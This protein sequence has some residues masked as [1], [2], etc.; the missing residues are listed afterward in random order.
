M[1]VCVCAVFLS[2]KNCKG[3]KSGTIQ[4]RGGGGGADIFQGPPLK[5]L[6]PGVC[7]CVCV[8]VCVIECARAILHI[9]DI[10][11]PLSQMIQW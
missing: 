8:C 4:F 10:L 3:S 11:L 9:Q 7:V 2:E 5:K 1:C 6:N